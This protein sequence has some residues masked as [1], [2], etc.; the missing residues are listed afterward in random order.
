MSWHTLAKIKLLRQLLCQKYEI[1]HVALTDKRYQLMFDID[2]K[3]NA[4]K[5]I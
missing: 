4:K 3:R 2:T 1:M 5:A